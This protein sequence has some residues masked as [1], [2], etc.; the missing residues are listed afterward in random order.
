MIDGVE[1]TQ[2][3]R[4]AFMLEYL[5]MK[6]KA[7][8]ESGKK[9]FTLIELIIVI[10]ILAIL[11]MILVPAVGKYIDNANISKVES[12]ART[13]YTSA[14]LAI[15]TKD[16]AELALTEAKELANLPADAVATIGEK[17]G[18]VVITLTDKGYTSEFDGTTFTTSKVAE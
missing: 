16:T 2:K 3:H 11:A 13:F 14:L 18:K 7:L 15:E 4:E 8:K 6:R 17:E 9:G 12:N 10:A 1:N 5:V